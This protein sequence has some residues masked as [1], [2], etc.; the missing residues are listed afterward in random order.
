MTTPRIIPVIDVMGGVVVHAVAGKREAYRPL[1]SRL[2]DSTHPLQV[3]LCLRELTGAGEVYVADL[4]AIRDG[5]AVSAQVERLLRELPVPQ[6]VDVGIGPV[7]SGSLLPA[8]PH[9]RP[10]VGLETASEPRFLTDTLAASVSPSV[11]FSIDLSGGR[12]LGNWSAWGAE[13][14]RD[15]MGVVR[16]VAELGVRTL[17]AL[18]LARVGTGSGTGSD[19]LLRTIR[20]AFPDVE[21]IAGGGV[22]TWADV[23]R[24]GDAGAS[25]V[26]VAT[27]IHTGSI[28]FPRPVP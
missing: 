27:A 12:L 7:R 23:D 2:T 21:L 5:N 19:E 13:H 24:L 25:A 20:G 26:L 6:W 28:T 15:V 18:D 8:L 4:D 14:E 3:G 10:V 22:R 16:R 11:A 9:V 17:I 1:E